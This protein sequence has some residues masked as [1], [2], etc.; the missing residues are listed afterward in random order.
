MEKSTALY[1]LYVSSNTGSWC[2]RTAWREGWR[3]PRCL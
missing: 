1:S 3:K 2:V